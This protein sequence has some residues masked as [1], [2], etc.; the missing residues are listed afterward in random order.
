MSSLLEIFS[1]N[2]IVFEVIGYPMSYVELVG[3]LTGL[4]CVWLAARSNILTWPVGLVNV[5]CF[6][7]I[8]YQVNLY[9]DML[10]QVYFFVMSLYGWYY[11]KQNDP[12]GT[13]VGVIPVRERWMYAGIMLVC[14]LMLGYAVARFHVWMPGWFPEAASYPY[15]DAYTTVLSI[16]ATVLLARK[17]WEAWILWMMVDTVSI[18]LYYLKGIMFIS[19]EYVVFWCMSL[20][21]VITWYK[22]IGH[23]SGTDSGKIHAAP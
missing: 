14:M 7:A 17:K 5:V 18:Y 11:W 21:G 2:N 10:L 4:I 22:L 16:A 13:K 19:L 12:R 6:F 20:Y 1:I 23:E 9:S 8:F 3:T 15:P